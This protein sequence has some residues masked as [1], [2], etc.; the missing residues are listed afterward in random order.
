MN[1]VEL[2]PKIQPLVAKRL[3]TLQDHS[4]DRQ[5]EARHKIM[6]TRWIPDGRAHPLLESPSLLE[7]LVRHR[8]CAIELR[9]SKSTG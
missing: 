6:Q 2:I 8:A 3:P 1:P 7:D 4:T 5:G 9:M